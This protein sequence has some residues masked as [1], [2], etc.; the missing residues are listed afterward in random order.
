MYSYV[1][2]Y[3][4]LSSGGQNAALRAAPES[5]CASRHSTGRRFRHGQAR[6]E[7]CARH[8]RHRLGE[9]EAV[10]ERRSLRLYNRAP[11]SRVGRR[12][13]GD[14]TQCRR[15]AGRRG[16]PCRSRPPVRT[17]QA[18]EGQTRNRIRQCWY[19]AVCSLGQDHRGALRRDLRR[20]CEKPSVHGA[21]SACADAGRRVDYPQCIDRRQQR[22][23]RVGVYSA[24]KA[25]V[26][27]FART[28]T[29]DVKDRRIRVN[30]VSPG[31]IDTPGLSGLL[32]ASGAAEQRRK[33]ISNA[34]PLGRF[35][36]P[37]EV[38]NAVVFLAS[39]DSSYVTGTEL[40]VDAGVAQV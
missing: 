27:S 14:R 29:T 22:V 3:T 15:R 38:A 6:R 25:A 17:E 24:T 13:Q 26:R 16:E 18:G 39:D 31:Y 2:A 37:D 23:A 32:A 9:R 21:E 35:G 12:G 8:R 5:G 36:T 30:A 19:R 11:R 10:R 33:T 4:L 20:Q 1:G 7:D 40:F 34:V 28:W